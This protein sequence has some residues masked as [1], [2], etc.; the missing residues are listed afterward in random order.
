MN[1]E[2]DWFIIMLCSVAGFAF[3][4]CMLSLML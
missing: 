3:A 2:A 4:L 1:D